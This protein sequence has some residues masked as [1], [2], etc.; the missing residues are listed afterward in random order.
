MIHIMPSFADL[1]LLPPAIA[2]DSEVFMK[3]DRIA[4]R[5]RNKQD[6]DEIVH[7]LQ[8]YPHIDIQVDAQND[9]IFEPV[10]CQ[11]RRLMLVWPQG[12]T[13][14]VLLWDGGYYACVESPTFQALT[15]LGLH[16][17]TVFCQ[18]DDTLETVLMKLTNKSP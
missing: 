17:Q 14:G 1:M 3:N 6:Q 9:L 11:Y 4:V 8:H 12:R 13:E 7:Q 5:T 16:V 10:V 2:P 18:P 15:A